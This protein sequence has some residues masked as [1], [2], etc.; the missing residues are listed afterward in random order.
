M[1]SLSF[2]VFCDAWLSLM[3]PLISVFDFS[4]RH[5]FSHYHFRHYDSQPTAFDISITPALA[6]I[7]IFD[8]IHIDDYSHH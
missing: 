7:F 3:P 5:R 4:F 1:V 2:C 8:A 6:A